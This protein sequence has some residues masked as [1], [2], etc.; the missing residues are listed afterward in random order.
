MRNQNTFLDGSITG[1]PATDLVV[2]NRFGTQSLMAETSQET[3]AKPAFNPENKV[4]S[5]RSRYVAILE[6]LHKSADYVREQQKVLNEIVQQFQLLSGYLEQTDLSKG[7]SSHA[8]SVYLMHAQVVRDCMNREFKNKPLFEKDN[9]MPLRIHIPINNEIEAYDLPLPCLRS[10]IPLGAFLHGVSDRSI[11][12]IGLIE[13]CM[14]AVTSVLLEVQGARILISDSTREC[15]I[16]RDKKAITPKLPVSRPVVPMERD[17][18][19]ATPPQPRR[20]FFKWLQ[21]LLPGR[22]LAA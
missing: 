6:N 16:L 19:V 17:H 4:F 20:S 8:W 9:G 1:E 2:S 13:D 21:G 18:S 22:Q 12:S 10:I 7:V 5:T 11:P 3:P 15:R 14:T